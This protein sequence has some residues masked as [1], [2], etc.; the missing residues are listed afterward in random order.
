GEDVVVDPDVVGL[1]AR[2]V[3][4]GPEELYRRGDVADQVAAEFDVLHLAPR[5]V[6][7]LIAYRE[8]DGVARLRLLPAVFHHVLL[9]QHAARFLKREVFLPLPLRAAAALAPRHRLA[10][11]VAAH[12]DARRHKIGNPGIGA[13]EHHVLAGGFEVVVLDRV[14]AGTVPAAD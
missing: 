3:G 9:D 12:D 13:A 1:P 2:V 4:V 14:A 7:V 11:D 6:A 5:A 10:E 8:Q